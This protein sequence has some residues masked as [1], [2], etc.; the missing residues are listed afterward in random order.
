MRK[1]RLLGGLALSV[2]LVGCLAGCDEGTEVSKPSE[3]STTASE[4][5]QWVDANDALNGRVS[6]AHPEP[7]AQAEVAQAAEPEQTPKPKLA[8]M[9]VVT[10][11]VDG[12]TVDLDNGETV[13]VVGIDTPERGQ[14][15]YETATRKMRRLVLGKVVTLGESDEDQDMYGRLLRYIDVS[16]A[17]AGLEMIRSG[18]AIARYDSRDGYGAHPR[19]DQYIAADEASPT[20]TCAPKPVAL[21]PPPQASNNCMVG[22]DPCLPV[23]PDLDCADIGGAVSVTG[24]DPYRLDADGDGIGCDLN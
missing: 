13:R 8:T 22:Y 6:S 18:L 11:V 3:Q 24:S 4:Q 2:V 17:D 21:Q 19:E 14:C 5:Q 23:V 9:Y 12:D 16:K 15:N 20:G 10:R 1:H 7:S